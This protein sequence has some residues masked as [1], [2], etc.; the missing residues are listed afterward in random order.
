[1]D[2]LKEVVLWR[3]ETRRQGA[4]LNPHQVQ[5]KRFKK[6]GNGFKMLGRVFVT[7]MEEYKSEFR[8]NQDGK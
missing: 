1:M 8:R 5:G 2:C 6:W 3:Q 4:V 7:F